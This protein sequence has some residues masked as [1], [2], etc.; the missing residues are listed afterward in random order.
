MF[1]NLRTYTQKF[2]GP[3]NFNGGCYQT[4]KE[5]ITSILYYLFQKTEEK[6]LP[7][8]LHEVSITLLPKLD[9][10]GIR[11]GSYRQLSLMNID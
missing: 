8:S 7:N 11:K 4:F 1:K 5:E 3:E 10:G 9:K 6:S 2:S